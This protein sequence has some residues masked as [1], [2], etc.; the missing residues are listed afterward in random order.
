LTGYEGDDLLT[1]AASSQQQR[2]GEV[3][4]ELTIE[5]FDCRMPNAIRST[6]RWTVKGKSTGKLK[7]FEQALEEDETLVLERVRYIAEVRPGRVAVVTASHTVGGD[8]RARSILESLQFSDGPDCFQ[9]EIAEL[10]R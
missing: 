1:R 5:E 7:E 4:E 9:D 2:Q 3:A 6:A 8:E 10:S